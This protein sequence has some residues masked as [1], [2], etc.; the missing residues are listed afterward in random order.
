MKNTEKSEEITSKDDKNNKIE[1]EIKE[2][3]GDMQGIPLTD[4]DYQKDTKTEPTIKDNKKKKKRK[5]IKTFNM[6]ATLFFSF[7]LVVV[8]IAQYIT[9]NRQANIAANANKLAQYQYRFEF[10]KKLEDLQKDV[11]II[12]K[13]AQQDDIEQFSELNY[14]ILSLYRESALL[15]D[16]NIS[17]DI[18]KILEEHLE[19]LNELNNKGMSYDGYEKKMKNLN[20]E[21]GNFINSD[22]FKKY[23]DINVIE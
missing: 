5:H 15:F 8:G 16:K 1:L 21:Y 12:K 23:L 18:N 10:Y 17:K 14:K 22:N 20:T 7:L 3:D 6:I 11:S 2:N 13:N 4:N 9:Y 19:F